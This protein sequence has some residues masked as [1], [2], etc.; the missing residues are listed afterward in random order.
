MSLDKAQLRA[1]KARVDSG[2]PL[3][4]DLP[5]PEPRKKR[6]NEEWRIQSNFFTWWRSAAKDLG[7]WPGLLYHIPNGSMLG[8]TK[9]GRMI[10][11]KMLKSSGM[12]SGVVDCFLAVPRATCSPS[13]TSVVIALASVKSGLYIEFKK[14]SQRTVKNGGLSDA[15]QEFLGYAMARGYACHVCYSWEEAR[16]VT[17]NYLT[18]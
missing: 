4:G 6:D 17:T 18:P 2:L 15:Q 11:A 10:R 9:K 14:P 12:V 7:V 8:D 3:A 1:L 13:E 5:A 16:D